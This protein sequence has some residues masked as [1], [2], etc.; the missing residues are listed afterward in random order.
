[1]SVQP[2]SRCVAGIDLLEREGDAARTIVFLH[3]IGGRA[4][5]FTDV[6]KRWPLGPRLIAWDMPGYGGSKPLTAKWATPRHFARRLV[7]L[8]E[9]L[10]AQGCDLVGQSLGGL[11]AG[12][13]AA[14]LPEY[15]VHRH[16]V[17]VSP[18]LGYKAPQTYPLP[19]GL[20]QRLEDFEREGAEAFAAKRAARL[21]FDA[22]QKVGATE[23]VKAAMASLTSAGHRAAVQALA[24]GDLLGTAPSI[25]GSV[26]LIAGSEDI[27][28]P[29]SGTKGL[30]TEL[31]KRP[32]LACVSETLI[33]L[34]RAGHAAYLE[35]PDEFVAAIATGLGGAPS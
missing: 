13:A 28:T 29:L 4:S 18:A 15:R 31:A 12:T 20:A 25:P 1:M 32:R 34:P 7:D 17:L 16:L 21:V 22:A 33:E 5:S 3:G 6:M 19:S 27:I 11:I 26:L 35:A 14:V 10:N 30:L 8:I 9:A 24:S 2:T 23:Q